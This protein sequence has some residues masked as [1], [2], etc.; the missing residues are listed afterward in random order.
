MKLGVIGY[1][2]RLRH[3]VRVMKKHDPGCVLTAVADLDPGMVARDEVVKSDG[4]A[5]FTSADDLM[6]QADMDAVAIG[7]RCSLHTRLALPV[8][9]RGLP[10]FLEKPVATG[11]DDLRR[12]Y[13]ASLSTRSPAVVSFPLRGTALARL[14]KEIV[15]SGKIGTVEHVQAVNNVPYGN[16]YFQGWYRDE[17]ETKGL[18]LQKATHD[19]DYINYLLGEMPVS[20]CAMKSKRIFKGVKPAGLLCADCDEKDACLESAVLKRALGEAVLGE[21][22]CFAVDTGNEDSGS[23]IVRYASGMHVNYSQNFFARKGAQARG[24]TLLGYLGTLQFDFFKGVVKVFMHHTA[25]TETYELEQGENHYG[26][27]MELAREFVRVVKEGGPSAF[28][29]EAGILSALMCLRATQSAETQT[30][31]EIRY[32]ADGFRA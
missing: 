15:G 25:R 26:G 28:P 11:Y 12:L 1:G 21:G 23:A 5:I 2:E 29:L 22:C 7:T 17:K 19:F 10:L 32:S 6:R 8:L 14:V 16:V 3:M 20:V 24:A 18:F 31:Q 13:D 27:D 4:A 9:E 30:F